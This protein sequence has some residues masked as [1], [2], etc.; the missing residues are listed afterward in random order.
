[1]VDR[2]VVAGYMFSRGI[3]W[4]GLVGAVSGGIL[5]LPIFIIGALFGIFIGGFVG[6][7]VGMATGAIAGAITVFFFYP[8]KDVL[9]YRVAISVV[10]AICAAV[11]TYIGSLQV[12]NFLP[13]GTV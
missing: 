1:M 7:I 8:V 10:C 3:K 2:N 4:G 6:I 13:K 11:F 9:H 12:S 5:G